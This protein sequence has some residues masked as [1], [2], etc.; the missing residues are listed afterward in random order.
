MSD[1]EFRQAVQRIIAKMA[2]GIT[3]TDEEKGLFLKHRAR[4]VVRI[5]REARGS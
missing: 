5:D 3:L 2:L 1:T 4:E